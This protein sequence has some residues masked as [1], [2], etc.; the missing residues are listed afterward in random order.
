VLCCL[1]PNSVL[2]KHVLRPYWEGG[3][4]YTW[5]CLLTTRVALLTRTGTNDRVFNSVPLTYSCAVL[6]CAM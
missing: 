5:T 4:R 3:D 1:V 6:R 2:T